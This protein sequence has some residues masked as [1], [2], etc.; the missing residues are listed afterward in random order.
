MCII[1]ESGVIISGGV[2]GCI[3]RSSKAV[4]R[5]TRFPV[6]MIR[7]NFSVRVEAGSVKYMNEETC[8]GGL[9]VL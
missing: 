7:V 5:H 8:V 1:K 6:W 9:E 2:E 4:M 3:V